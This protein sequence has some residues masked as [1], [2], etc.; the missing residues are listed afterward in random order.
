[1]KSK[2]LSFVLIAAFAAN[3]PV[4]AQEMT[5]ATPLS[6]ASATKHTII[7]CSSGSAHS[8][9]DNFF[10]Q[11]G[12]GTT[13]GSVNP[14]PV[15][16][17]SNVTFVAAHDVN[18]YAVKNDGT[19]W[20]WGGNASGQVGDGT[21][22]Q[23]NAPVQVLTGVSK[24]AAGNRHVVALK[25]DGT[26]WTWGLNSTGQLGTGNTTNRS[27]P[28][29][30]PGLTQVIAVAAGFAHSLALKSDGTVWS[31][32]FNGSHQLGDGTTTQ[33]LSPVASS[34]TGVTAIASEWN[35]S[36]AIK[37]GGVWAWGDNAYGQLGNN[38]VSATGSEPVACLG[39][40]T[41][42]TKIASGSLH[43]VALK[44]DGSV[45]TWGGNYNGQLG[46]GTSTDKH[47]PTQ[48]V[49]IGGI[50]A[51]ATGYNSSFAIKSPGTIVY[52]WGLNTAG[53]L[54]DGTT[55]QRNSP[56]Q[57][58]NLCSLAGLDELSGNANEPA[59]NP[60]VNNG[61]F[62]ITFPH[63]MKHVRVIVFNSV[64]AKVYEGAYQGVSSKEIDLGN[65]SS[66]V[67]FVTIHSEENSY[68]KKI[69][70]D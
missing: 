33:R 20:G 48:V 68:L 19:L 58:N 25:T 63:S 61:T 40:T 17:L 14:V 56:V 45:W 66:G 38:L 52:A 9:G 47:V 46:D 11:L 23:R 7:I 29:Q 69:I 1:M 10:G 37:S 24:V 35:H 43:S 6:I 30:V 18:S 59:L 13:T 26:V 54:G 16:G 64:G 53:L 4:M 60:T 51:I 22:T 15:S 49:S 34:L 2:L 62:I 41:G 32:G 31:W 55:A 5:Q 36:L 28:G 42:M 44:S 3:M 27:T 70:K 50:S 67:Y 57:V 39:I 12:N 21:T 65:I 8:V